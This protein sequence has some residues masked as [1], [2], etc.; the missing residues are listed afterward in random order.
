MGK[1]Y[2]YIY[3]AHE[4]INNDKIEITAWIAISRDSVNFRM[5]WC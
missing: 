3:M 1:A 2:I 5:H 4:L